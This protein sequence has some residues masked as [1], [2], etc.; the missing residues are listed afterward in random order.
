[1]DLPWSMCAIMEKF[2][3]LLLS[4]I[5]FSHWATM[6]N[7][8]WTAKVPLPHLFF[9]YEPTTVGVYSKSRLGSVNTVCKYGIHVFTFQL[10]LSIFDNIGASSCK[11][12]VK[13]ASCI[14]LQRNLQHLVLLS[15]LTLVPLVV[16]IYLLS[17]QWWSHLL[18]LPL[19]LRP[20][21]AGSVP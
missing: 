3:I 21:P 4:A 19:Q 1:V 8:L 2:L 10:F 14:S 6:P 20:P 7:Q 11:S 13:Q 9:A 18:Q 15:K 17:S 16:L 12:N 5:Q